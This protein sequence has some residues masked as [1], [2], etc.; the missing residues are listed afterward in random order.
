MRNRVVKRQRRRRQHFSFSVSVFFVLLLFFYFC[1]FS[2]IFD[3]HFFF[4]FVLCWNGMD[5]RESEDKIKERVLE[6][7]LLN[8]R[9]LFLL[10][11]ASII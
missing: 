1:R 7:F 8:Y 6:R 4:F 9:F 10:V 3:F 11:F 2:I 5:G